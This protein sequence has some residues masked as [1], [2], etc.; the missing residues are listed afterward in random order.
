[1]SSKRAMN[2]ADFFGKTSPQSSEPLI[3]HSDVSWADLSAA[4]LP[5]KHQTGRAGL[6]QV[7]LPG[8]GHG[9]LGGFS[10]LNISESPNDASACSLS[11]I[12]ETA[13]IPQRFFLSR[14]A[15]QGVLRRAEKRGKKLPEKLRL[16]LEGEARAETAPAIAEGK[17]P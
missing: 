3:T 11:Q 15:K 5:W 6:T 10:T 4:A 1:M 9:L 16:A 17:T 8:H 2:S 12:L 14:E 13:P 7:W